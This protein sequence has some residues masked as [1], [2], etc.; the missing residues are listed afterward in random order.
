MKCK[1]GHF[2]KEEPLKDE[3]HENHKNIDINIRMNIK[4]T[5]ILSAMLHNVDLSQLAKEK[6]PN[7]NSQSNMCYWKTHITNENI[8]HIKRPFKDI[9]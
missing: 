1:K 2:K 8:I 9:C 5:N 7:I 6:H 3:K 4:Q